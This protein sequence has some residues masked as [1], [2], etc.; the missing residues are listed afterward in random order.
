MNKLRIFLLL[1]AAAALIGAFVLATIGQGLAAALYLGIN[2]LVIIVGV[3]FERGRY[4]PKVSADGDWE[5]TNEKFQDPT[6]GKWMT[7][8][9]NKKTGERD[10]IEKK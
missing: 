6:T 10:Y 3:L 7:V 9:Y 8:R 2:G 5:V 4:Q 1:C